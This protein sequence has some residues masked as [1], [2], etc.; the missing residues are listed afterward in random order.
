MQIRLYLLLLALG[1]SL[2]L[3]SQSLPD[4]ENPQVTGINKEAPH[5]HFIPFPNAKNIGNK[6]ID[7][8]NYQSLNGIWKFHWVKTPEQRPIDFYRPNYDCANWA[9]IKVPG[10]WELQGFGVPI[11]TDEE[12]PFTPNPPYVPKDFNPVGSYKRSFEIPNN[13]TEKN[14]HLVFEGVRSAFYVW[15][16][17]QKAGYS[18][19]SKTPAEFNITPYLQ[20]GKND[21]AIE[22]Y[23]FSD[24]SY[25]EGQDYWKISGIERSVYL[26][27][28]PK[29]MIR[30]FSVHASLD[31]TY[32][33]GLF[34]LDV[35]LNNTTNNKIR[36]YQT[37]IWL[38]DETT[39]DTLFHQIK[40]TNIH[41]N[42]RNNLQFKT[43]LPQIQPWTAES[44]N[45]YRLHIQLSN[46]K[47]NPL[48]A[49]QSM[50]GFRNV[51]IMDG[52]L[53]ING[54]PITL[55][56]VNRHEHDPVNGR[57]ITEDCMLEDIRL[58]KQHNINAVRTSHYPNQWRWYELCDQ[59][60]LYLVDEANLECHGMKS[61]PDG[62]LANYPTWEN[63]HLDRAIRM[64]ERDK[65]HPSIIIW[66]MGNETGDGENFKSM[67][68]WIK[69]KDPS[70]PVQYEE[71]R[72][73]PHTDIVCPMYARIHHLKAYVEKT[74]ERPL[75]LCE[76]AHAMG[77]SVGNLQDYWDV[78]DAHKNLQGG[79]IWDW[80][81]QT[82]EQTDQNGRK[83][84]AYGGDMGNSGVPNDSN[85][86]ANG[87]VAANR[88]LH[89]HI[90]EVKKVYQPVK[91]LPLD[92]F[93]GKW[94]LLNRYDFTTLN[95]QTIEWEITANGVMLNKGQTQSSR[96]EP[97]Q[98]G[99]FT[100][101]MPPI[102]PESGTE[103]FIQFKVLS[104]A[105]KPFLPKGSI[106][107]WN[108]YRLK[109]PIRFK[110]T[111]EEVMPRLNY[112]I[113]DEQIR[114][115][116]Q[117]FTMDINTAAG[118]ITS[119]IFEGKEL[120]KKGPLADFW[121]SPTDNDL[122]NNMPGRSGIWKD[123]MHS[124]E[125]V[126]CDI[127]RLSD[128][129]IQVNIIQYLSKPQLSIN[130]QYTIYGSGDIIVHYQM[131][132]LEA[133]LPEIPR[134]GMTLLLNEAFQQLE[135]YGRGPHENYQ[136]RKTAAAIGLY[137]GLVK[138]QHTDYVRPQENGNKTD[139]RWLAL[140]S[141]EHIG[142][143]IQANPIFEFSVRNYLNSDLNHP[144]KG[145]HKHLSDVPVRDLITLNLNHK[146]MGVG[147]DNSWGAR[148]HKQYTLPA[149]AYTFQFR[150]RPFNTKTTTP[151]TLHISK[152]KT[153]NQQ[154][155]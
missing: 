52:Q 33:T 121:R 111:P 149:Q 108:Q 76:Y 46:R 89:P 153:D 78:I 22:V 60:G 116:G 64:V 104:N 82:F 10:N 132:P 109:L 141:K 79:F 92:P 26:V 130:T 96:V 133:D 28:R 36:K 13:W 73:K 127:Q 71:A 20:K 3:F 62:T 102:R 101:P 61:H 63:A 15:V 37:E 105:D 6:A 29:A 69:E 84:W 139:V 32:K 40:E 91:V 48:E 17:G 135:W 47:G 56:G 35:E 8:P 45:L 103:Y 110:K 25:L 44:P 155:Y 31:S 131:F 41:R 90:Q 115:V 43:R 129:V 18:Q 38:M 87:L 75:I 154:S 14:I 21:L 7:S 99:Q 51:E 67:Y 77:N 147:G 85:F 86:C 95:Q 112:L 66:S 94:I 81:D 150:M 106:L 68:R 24:G 16:N 42:S 34:T 145:H 124:L 11:Y 23:R 50:V 113:Q 27:T 53:K 125:N 5:A 93:G 138:D 143:F 146:Q 136:D 122:G 107:G 74:Q 126:D 134:I 100:I 137:K 118:I 58:M 80:V 57:A 59:Y 148:V 97:H 9:D 30:D 120:L 119:W 151:A 2:Q 117:D 39:Q 88:S 65:N 70:R 54:K 12:Y 128:K 72:Q 98:E 152:P 19:G 1:L 83:Y 114:L 140:L 49:L 142:L 144:G 123:A 4:W 55:F